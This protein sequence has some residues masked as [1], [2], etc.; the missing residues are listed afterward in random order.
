MH[1]RVEMH[2]TDK[3]QHNETRAM[4]RIVVGFVRNWLYIQI[5]Y[6]VEQKRTDSESYTNV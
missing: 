1:V 4:W 3:V 2:V 6:K 5:F